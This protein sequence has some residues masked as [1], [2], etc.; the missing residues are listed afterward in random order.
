MRKQ[1]GFT[2]IEALVAIIFVSC[3]AMAGGVLLVLG[4]FIAKFW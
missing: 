4:H 3:L 1:R 2:L